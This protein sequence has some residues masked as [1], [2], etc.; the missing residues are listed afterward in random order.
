M[1]QRFYVA[2]AD[3]VF[4]KAVAKINGSQII[5][6]APAATPLPIKAIRYAFTNF[7]LTNI[8][9]SDG[10]PMEPFRSDTWAQ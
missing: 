6:T 4:R 3:R 8:Q 10:L 9:N 2:G 7:P 5:L 1:E